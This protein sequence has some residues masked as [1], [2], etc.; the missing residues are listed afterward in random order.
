M[1]LKEKLLKQEVNA[2]DPIE[3]PKKIINSIKYQQDTKGFYNVNWA[4]AEI[5]FQMFNCIHE[6][7][8]NHW[9]MNENG[10][11]VSLKWQ[12]L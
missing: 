4:Q 2:F 11:P 10:F 6:I 9:V 3:G 7:Q 1:Y 8:I 5:S 12:V